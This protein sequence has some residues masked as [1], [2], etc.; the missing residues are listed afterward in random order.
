MRCPL[1]APASRQGR[2]LPLNEQTPRSEPKEPGPHA[3]KRSPRAERPLADAP[4]LLRPFV[5][6]SSTSIVRA[7]GK[8]VAM[9]RASDVDV[10][11]RVNG[12]WRDN[13][14]AKHGC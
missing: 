4:V 12:V 10:D 6:W 1:N 14:Q 5:N 8:A 7:D 3:K 9:I 13:D 11:T 2:R